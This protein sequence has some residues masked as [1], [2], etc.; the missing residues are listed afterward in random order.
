MCLLPGNFCTPS[1]TNKVKLG[2]GIGE[3][4]C[5]QPSKAGATTA[6]PPSVTKIL[7]V[8]EQVA[9]AKELKEEGG[10]K[11]FPIPL[12]NSPRE[13]HDHPQAYFDLRCYFRSNYD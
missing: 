3:E 8:E 11:A 12:Q 2:V 5:K 1:L 4:L 6:G 7:R 10:K 13:I 9:R